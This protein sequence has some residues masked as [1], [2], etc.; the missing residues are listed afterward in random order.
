MSSTSL[1]SSVPTRHRFIPAR[2]VPSSV[3]TRHRSIDGSKK[4]QRGSPPTSTSSVV[5]GEA[6][7]H[8]RKMSAKRK[9]LQ[10][11]GERSITRV[12]VSSH[13]VTPSCT[14]PTEST[15]ARRR[16]CQTDE[17]ASTSCES[18]LKVLGKLRNLLEEHSNPNFSF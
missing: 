17:S 11:E 6:S 18:K 16:R 12:K 5:T 9:P 15:I 1:S 3:P 4:I 13:R 7:E 10:K 2:A 8:S 14:G